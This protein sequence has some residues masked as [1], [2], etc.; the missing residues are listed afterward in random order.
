M[1][2]NESKQ[3]YDWIPFFRGVAGALCEIGKK[4]AEERDREIREAAE[5]V[6]T[7][8]KSILKPEYPFID[9]FSFMYTLSR[10]KGFHDRSVRAQG[11]FKI[12]E[13]LQSFNDF[14]YPHGLP[15]N[16][17]FHNNGYY[18]KDN[19][20][21]EG[22]ENKAVLDEVWD[23]FAN[24][25]KAE[26]YTAVSDSDFCKMLEWPYVASPKLTQTL[27]LINPS[28]FLPIDDRTLWLPLREPWSEREQG[29]VSGNIASG[30]YK[31]SKIMES[32]MKAFPGCRPY[33]INLFAY[34]L[35]SGKL[36]ISNAESL[37]IST[38]Y[39]DPPEDQWTQGYKFREKSCIYVDPHRDPELERVLECRPGNIMLIRSGVNETHAVGVAI[40]MPKS[41]SGLKEIEIDTQAIIDAVW[42][43]AEDKR[44]RVPG[45]AP[46]PRV[47]QNKECT[48]ASRKAYPAT[49]KLIDDIK[50][51]QKNEQQQKQTILTKIKKVDYYKY[52]KLLQ[53][54][55]NLILQGA[56][57]AG[58]TYI[59]PE[60]AMGI[61]DKKNIGEDRK[62]IIMP[63]YQKAIE[64]GQ[65]AFVTFHQS[66]DYEEFVEGWRPTRGTTNQ[67]SMSYE[68]RDGIFK[69]LCS[70]AAGDH[71]NNYVLIIDEINRGNVS[72]ILGELITL[73]EKDK[74]EGEENETRVILPYSPDSEEK[75]SVP[76]NLYI[77]GTM[78]TADR[79][80][81][82]IDY[83]V[84]RRFVFDT[85]QSD[86]KIMSKYSD[87]HDEELRKDAESLFDR[88]K[89]IFT[90][91]NDDKSEY[92][93]VIAD[94]AP[95]DIMVGHSYFLAKSREEL[96][97]N[98]KYQIKPLLLEYIKDG[99]LSSNVKEDIKNL[100][101]S[102]A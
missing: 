91:T 98:L 69:Q 11:Y 15:L 18:T 66:M 44:V 8:E 54:H 86:R 99:I 43:A 2:N 16:T 39:S 53:Q 62:K 37:M 77:I 67:N 59:T 101:L 90:G 56:P 55:K 14:E 32:F 79:S 72:K 64:D 70:N 34:M 94:V 82:H 45:G 75:F 7:K 12:S 6:F 25:Y 29:I 40:S 42:L 31:F 60:I 80:L 65:I 46:P 20:E 100:E 30:K 33:E 93:N 48:S 71:E 49:H 97:S 83:A 36:R 89:N 73:L 76:S 26:R 35:Q 5:A 92:N 57:G 4:D 95:D 52:V 74:R 13:E 10:K 87:Y 22:K 28:V 58:K 23:L 78:N 41:G 1:S 102:D 19:K 63:A 81:G 47:H 50:Q 51:K 68:V 24:V 88:V 61:I 21:P 17:L 9:P 96:E 38:R 84:R 85:L 3:L 27:F